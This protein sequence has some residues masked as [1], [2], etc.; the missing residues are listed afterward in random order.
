[1]LLEIVLNVLAIDDAIWSESAA[2]E[3]EGKYSLG[4][5]PAVVCRPNHCREGGRISVMGERVLGVDDG[6]LCGGEIT[7]VNSACN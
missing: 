3:E 7:R 5:K 6:G 1:M 4:E 2:S